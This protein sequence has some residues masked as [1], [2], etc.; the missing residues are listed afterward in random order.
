MMYDVLINSKEL[1]TKV[2]FIQAFLPTKVKF[3]HQ[4][5]IPIFGELE[6]AR[7]NLYFPMISA[8]IRMIKICKKVY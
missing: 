8:V 2:G 7:N 6:I 3:N 1:R 5:F 4:G